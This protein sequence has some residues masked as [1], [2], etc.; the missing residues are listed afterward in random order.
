MKNLKIGITQ[1]DING[2]GYEIIIKT[3]M[4]NRIME[5]C[6][7]IIY[8]STKVAAYHRKALDIDNFSFNNIRS[9]EE[10]NEK[11][12]NIINCLDDEIRV[13]LGKSTEMAGD[14][15]FKALEAA[16]IDLSNGKIDALVTAPINK[17]NIQ[18]ENFQFNGHTEYLQDVFNTPEVLMLMVSNLMKIGVVTGHIPISKVSEHI[19]KERILDKLRILNLSLKQDFGIRKPKIAVFGLNPHTGDNGLLGNEEI[20]II[21]PAIEQA[22][23]EEILSFGPYP[24]DG[25]FGSGNYTKFDAVLAMYHDQGLAPFKALIN[26]EGINYTAGLPIIRT[27]PAHGTAYEITG[28]NEASFGSFR[29]AIYLACEIYKN[30]KLYGEI[31]N[32]PLPVGLPEEVK[33]SKDHPGE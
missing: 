17:H 10:A 26:D 22:N 32:D 9:V 30:R 3:L 4:D 20:D 7:P 6:T 28:K 14:A 18:S 23:K 33:S 1:G 12:P 13:E 16:V 2:I 25:F 15:S 11:R 24:A 8:G 27:S 5:F 31:N 21:I 29:S 19:T